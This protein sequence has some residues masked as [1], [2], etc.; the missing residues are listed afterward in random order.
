MTF[1]IC[2]NNISTPL[3]GDNYLHFVLKC[4]QHLSTSVSVAHFKSKFRSVGGTNICRQKL[5]PVQHTRC[6][7]FFTEHSANLKSLRQ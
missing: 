5:A 7:L 1:L 2:R 4:N 6:A 3:R